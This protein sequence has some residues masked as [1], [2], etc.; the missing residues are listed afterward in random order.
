MSVTIECARCGAVESEF[1]YCRLADCP[2]LAE[3][4]LTGSGEQEQPHDGSILDSI[5]RDI[6]ALKSD[7]P[8]AS[9]IGYA[10]AHMKEALTVMRVQASTIALFERDYDAKDARIP[11]LE[12]ALR[13]ARAFIAGVVHE[14]VARNDAD[15]TERLG[16]LV[17][18]A[19]SILDETG[20]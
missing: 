11:L 5:S 15:N 7:T 4:S 1:A 3:R 19:A 16:A 17:D 6:A 20:E 18:R 10:V 9:D 2:L 13:K 14:D 12:E 8:S